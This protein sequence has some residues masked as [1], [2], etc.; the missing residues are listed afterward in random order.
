MT[1]TLVLASRSPRRADLL[2]SIGM[3]F[4]VDVADVDETPYPDEHPHGLVERLARAKSE[5]VSGPGRVVVGA[6]TVVVLDGA[7][8]GKPSHPSEAEAML[9]RL[10]EAAHHVVSGVAVTVLVDGEPTTESAV[11]SAL[12]RFGPMTDEEVADYVATGEPLDCAG[13]YGIQGRGGVFVEGI[14][15]HPST[16]VGLPLPATIRLLARVGL[17]LNSPRERREPGPGIAAG[18][19]PLD[20]R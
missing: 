18:E 14:E 7:V 9:G 3:S 5:A 13:A 6:D 17:G 4:Q 2:S 16:V 19:L 20:R 10:R 11:E 1:R 8:L 15:G 12:V